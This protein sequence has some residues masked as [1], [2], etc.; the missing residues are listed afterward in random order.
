ML[1][2]VAVDL[3]YVLSGLPQIRHDSDFLYGV[4]QLLLQSIIE[5]RIILCIIWEDYLICVC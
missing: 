5:A 4:R 3:T 1:A 2:G